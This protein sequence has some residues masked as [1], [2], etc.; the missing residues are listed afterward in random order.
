M[1]STC[2]CRPT[3]IAS[4]P[5][6]D[7]TLKKAEIALAEAQVKRATDQLEWAKKVFD[8]GFISQGDLALK[9]IDVMKARLKLARTRAMSNTG[10]DAVGEPEDRWHQLARRRAMNNTGKNTRSDQDRDEKTLKSSLGPSQLQLSAKR[11]AT[12]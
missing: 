9:E 6:T 8:K 10:E 7:S 11:V 1:T 4:E 12:Q 3:R 2:K 5:T